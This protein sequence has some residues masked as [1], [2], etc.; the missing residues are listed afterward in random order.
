MST[1]FRNSVAR[2]FGRATRRYLLRRS[3]ALADFQQLDADLP[4]V[5]G[6]LRNEMALTRNY[7]IP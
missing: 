3:T 1:E 5:V 4:K 2:L 6:E 7:G